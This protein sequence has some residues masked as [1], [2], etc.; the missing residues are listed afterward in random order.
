[1]VDIAGQVAVV[2]GAAGG[3]G[4]ATAQ[5][6]GR[7]GATVIA[8]DIDASR[9]S[10]AWPDAPSTG[11]ELHTCD[12]SKS[13]EIDQLISEVASEHG[14]IGILINSAGVYRDGAALD[15]TE[16][17]FDLM[18]SV[19]VKGTFLMS[20]AV[21]RTMVAASSGGSVVNIASIAADLSSPLNMAYGATKAAVLS[22]TRGLAVSLA[23][24]GIRVNAIAPGPVETAM[25]AQALTDP[26]YSER[27]LGRI[28][29]GRLGTP[30]EIAKS[31]LFLASDDS[32][33]ITGSC[34]TVDGGVRALR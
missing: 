22:L 27:M 16:S 25:A 32:S 33:W 9:L 30:D 15:A 8:V 21:A 19:N 31:A 5:R 29:L 6:L 4:L 17:D 26:A 12:I 13:A 11:V 3:I 1:M 20:Q 14:A 10:D 28:L 7:E 23:T 24:H 18:Y 2:T 34:L